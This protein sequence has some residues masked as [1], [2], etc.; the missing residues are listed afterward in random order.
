MIAGAWRSCPRSS[1]VATSEE[2]Q[3]IAAHHRPR[4]GRPD[5]QLRI[6]SK[7]DGPVL[8][9]TDVGYMTEYDS[10]VEPVLMERA[11]TPIRIFASL[12]TAPAARWKEEQGAGGSPRASDA[13]LVVLNGD[14]AAERRIL[15]TS[16][17]RSAAGDLVYRIFTE[18]Y[19][20]STIHAVPGRLSLPV[21]GVAGNGRRRR[22]CRAADR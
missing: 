15:R 7:A 21:G 4:G 19:C 18:K 10:T 8:F 17:A 16:A 5:E 13:D 14:P 22:R 11:Q 1:C 2:G 9:G 3:G 6:F 12:T 20:R